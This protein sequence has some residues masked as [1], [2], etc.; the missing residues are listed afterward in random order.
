MADEKVVAEFCLIVTLTPKNREAYRPC[1]S[2]RHQ[3][4]GLNISLEDRRGSKLVQ[5]EMELEHCKYNIRG[6]L[7]FG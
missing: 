7:D 3:T 5:L 4:D 6:G 2:T 1:G